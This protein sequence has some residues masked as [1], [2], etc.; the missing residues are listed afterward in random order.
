MSYSTTAKVFFGLAVDLSSDK[1][2]EVD[3][4]YKDGIKVCFHGCEG[5]TVHCLHIV[6]SMRSVDVYSEAPRPLMP[7]EAAA[8]WSDAL[9]AFCDRHGFAWPAEGAGWRLAVSRF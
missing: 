2:D 3:A 4:D 1:W 8:E 5:A 6:G 9:R 7:L